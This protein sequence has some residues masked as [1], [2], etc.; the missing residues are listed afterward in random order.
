MGSDLSS[1]AR[2]GQGAPDLQT[3]KEE[4]DPDGD[5]QNQGVLQYPFIEGDFLRPV[6][7]GQDEAALVGQDG[8]PVH[9]FVDS[10]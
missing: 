8:D 4:Q 3:D 6:G 7:P 5:H 10:D 1:V 2:G 9:A